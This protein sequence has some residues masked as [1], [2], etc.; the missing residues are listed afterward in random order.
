MPR[1]GVH[2]RIACLAGGADGW[3][4]MKEDTTLA[5]PVPRAVA[6]NHL[7][8]SRPATRSC[9]TTL[10]VGP[11][12]I[13]PCPC[14]TSG[15]GSSRMGGMTG[16]TRNTCPLRRHGL[17]F[18]L[19]SSKPPIPTCLIRRSVI[20]VMAGAHISCETPPQLNHASMLQK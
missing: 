16:H 6:I 15:V 11:L 8:L 19:T 12:N 7:Y 4:K 10:C 2:C 5:K 3:C 14:S 9:C 13:L 18:L 1:S 17:V 20:F